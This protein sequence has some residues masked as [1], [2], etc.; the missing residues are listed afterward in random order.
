MNTRREIPYLRAPMHYPL[1]IM[2][3]GVSVVS[4]ITCDTVSLLVSL[5]IVVNFSISSIVAL[6]IFS[7]TYSCIYSL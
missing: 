4:R 5:V 6:V 7:C 1:E 2:S 3:F